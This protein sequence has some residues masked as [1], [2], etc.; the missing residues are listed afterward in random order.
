MI[1]RGLAYVVP[2]QLGDEIAFEPVVGEGDGHVGLAAAVRDIERL[3]L[4]E[5][6]EAGRRET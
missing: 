2:G 1:D 6:A 5:A 3:G 4:Y